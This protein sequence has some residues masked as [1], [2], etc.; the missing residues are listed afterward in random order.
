M[1]EIRFRL[2]IMAPVAPMTHTRGTPMTALG[3]RTMT[4]LA[5]GMTPTLGM[6]PMAIGMTPAT[7]GTTPP[8]FGTTL[9]TA[10]PVILEESLVRTCT[11]SVTGMKII[12]P[13]MLSSMG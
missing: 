12:A 11:S 5:L 4:H 2:A 13:P 7:V 8:T 10:F 3:T 6:T 1:G 9:L